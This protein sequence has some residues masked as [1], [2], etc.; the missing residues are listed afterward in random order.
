MDNN[1]QWYY[2]DRNGQQ[3]GPVSL[4]ELQSLLQQSAVTDSSMAWTE[5]MTDWKVVSDID[6]LQPSANEALAQTT[7]VAQPAASPLSQPAPATPLT[8]STATTTVEANPYAT[9]KSNLG[10]DTNPYA[11]PEYGGIRRLAYFAR[12]L[13]TT[14]LFVIVAVVGGVMGGEPALVLILICALVFFILYIRFALLRIRNIGA[15]GWWLLLMLVP[16]ASNA[17]A[18]VLLACPEGFADHKKMD[19]IGIIVAVILGGLTLLSLFAN[20]ATAFA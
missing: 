16:V 14:F 7:P 9:P 2:T 4:T 6:V 8:T 19:T 10:I 17:L 12:I 18:I 20:F 1:Q 5:G 3:A 15:S 13:L 11:Q